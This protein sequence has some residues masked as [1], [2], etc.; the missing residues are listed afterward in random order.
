MCVCMF[1]TIMGKKKKK[2]IVFSLFFLCVSLSRSHSPFSFVF[3]FFQCIFSFVV[4][5]QSR[6]YSDR[7]REEKKRKKNEISL[8]NKNT[9]TTMLLLFTAYRPTRPTLPSFEEK[10][11]REREKRRRKKEEEIR[12]CARVDE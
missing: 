1:V 10:K 2:C 11:K 9:I 5:A 3:L 12:L 7:K 6:G 4:R 8:S